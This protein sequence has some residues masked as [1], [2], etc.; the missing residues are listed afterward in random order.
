MWGKG[1]GLSVLFLIIYPGWYKLFFLCFSFD[2]SLDICDLHF[3]KPIK[4]DDIGI[5]FVSA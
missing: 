4:V 1:G 2:T 5:E 3:V